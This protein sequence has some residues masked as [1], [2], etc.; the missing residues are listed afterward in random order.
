MFLHEGKYFEP[1]MRD[2]EGFLTDT[3]DTVNGQ[4]YLKLY[5]YRFELEGIDSEN[6]LMN[7]TF[8]QYGESNLAWTGEDAKGFTKIFSNAD[9][10][11]YHVNQDKR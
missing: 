6:D 8:G 2:I 10:I 5:P 11:Y 3:Q 9:K 4:V 7:S 1:V